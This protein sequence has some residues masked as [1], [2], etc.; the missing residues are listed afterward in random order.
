[1][2][3][4]ANSDIAARRDQLIA[5]AEQQFQSGQG[6]LAMQTV[7]RIVEMGF[8][9]WDLLERAWTEAEA[10]ENVAY[11]DQVLGMI[12]KL[13]PGFEHGQLFVLRARREQAAFNWDKGIPWLRKAQQ[14][15]DLPQKERLYIAEAQALERLFR[16]KDA[17]KVLDRDFQ[18]ENFHLAR[19]VEGNCL[20][21]AGRPDEARRM[22][23]N[24]L[25]D[26]PASA[27][28]VSGRRLLGQLL[29]KSGDY[30][31]AW[32]EFRKGNEIAGKVFQRRISRNNVRWRTEAWRALYGKPK[33]VERLNNNPIDYD[34]FTPVFL[35]GFPRSGTTL[36]EQMLDAH[37]RI[38]TLEE[39]PMVFHAIGQA[40]AVMQA[41][42]RI[43]GLLRDDMH[44]KE[45]AVA[46]YHELP[47]L[48]NTEMGKLRELYFQVAEHYSP[49]DRNKVLVDKQPLNLG[50]I[51]FIL[52]L[53][54]RA[55]FIVAL[56][57]PAD[58]V[59]SCLMQNFS[60]NDGMANFLDPEHA[61]SFY[62]HIMALLWQYEST[63]GIQEQIHYIRY[64]DMLDD[65]GGEVGRLLE[66][67]GLEWDDGVTR[68]DEHARQ[69]GSLSTPSYQ[70][71]T[72]KLYKGSVNRWH[73]Y[74]EQLEPY[75]H[76]FRDAAKRYGYS[77]EM[78]AGTAKN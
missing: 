23:E 19:Q 62:K 24:W 41:R 66:F 53:F 11:M 74:A 5:Q 56:R 29:D 70:G 35:V 55:K 44:R 21:Q 76:Y 26:A 30:D 60:D 57:H 58:C 1:M 72:R 22:L 40:V 43:K 52:R 34:D 38:Q 31:A 45:Y 51:G 77:L 10:G 15:P 3:E 16:P 39:K 36:L 63:L 46:S 61:A 18:G 17:L 71:V 7:S 14:S 4:V 59:L 68:Y 2:T 64:E 12:D 67:M 37:G 32:E 54:P 9:N 27:A 78:P 48:G 20:Q 33:W 25:P 8:L 73:N 75:L 42:A 6:R 69:R 65:F 13:A 49:I 50:D 47:A 28:T